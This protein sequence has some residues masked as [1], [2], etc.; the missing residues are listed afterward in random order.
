MFYARLIIAIHRRASFYAA[1]L[2]EPDIEEATVV[3]LKKIRSSRDEAG[4]RD[5]A[6]R[7]TNG[8][9]ADRNERDCI[10]SI[11]VRVSVNR[12]EADTG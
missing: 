2:K 7:S 5:I 8:I 3:T 12:A 11:D 4:L 1:A 9:F 6:A 10:H